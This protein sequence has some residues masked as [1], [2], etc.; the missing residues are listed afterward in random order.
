MRCAGIISGIIG[1]INPATTGT[2]VNKRND[3]VNIFADIGNPH[4]DLLTAELHPCRRVFPFLEIRD[5]SCYNRFPLGPGRHRDGVDLPFFDKNK[6][7]CQEVK[8][9]F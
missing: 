4:D 2:G 5:L 8:D 1:I 3:Q 7:I 6:E 9:G